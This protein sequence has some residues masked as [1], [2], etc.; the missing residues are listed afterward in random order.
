MTSR[1]GI[2]GL[3]GYQ[4]F[5]LDDDDCQLIDRCSRPRVLTMEDQRTPQQVMNDV[6]QLLA[7]KHEFKWDSVKPAT[8]TRDRGIIMAIPLDKNRVEPELPAWAQIK[9]NDDA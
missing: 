7:D 9:D 8:D 5:I 1:S 2:P 4:R 3:A 6:W